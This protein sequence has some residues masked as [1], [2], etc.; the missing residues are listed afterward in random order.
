MV[1]TVEITDHATTAFARATIRRTMVITAKFTTTVSA[2]RAARTDHA[3]T[4]NA[5]AAAAMLGHNV[6]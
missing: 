2:L 6:C 5:C 1:S 3:T 4:A